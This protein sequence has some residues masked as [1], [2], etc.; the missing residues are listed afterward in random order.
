MVILR[1][2]KLIFNLVLRWYWRGC[3]DSAHDERAQRGHQ[4]ETPACQDDSDERTADR[5][6]R[7][8]R[9]RRRRH[10]EGS[11]ELLRKQRQRL[12]NKIN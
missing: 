12:R 2:F 3:G 8:L 10:P 11:R 1:R 5:A 9:D 6:A 4:P 7:A